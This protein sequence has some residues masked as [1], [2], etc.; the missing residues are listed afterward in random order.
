MFNIYV[1]KCDWVYRKNDVKVDELGFTLVDLSKIGHK[2]DHFILATQ[3][4]QVFY[5]EDQVD[6]RWSIV[7]SR[8]KMELFS[9]ESD[10]NITDNCM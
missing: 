3:S 1:F 2:S 10:D 8:P 9:I 4:Q 6:P 7:L 5:V